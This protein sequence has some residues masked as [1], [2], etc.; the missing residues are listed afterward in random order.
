ME[1]INTSEV[2]SI[3]FKGKTIIEP[4]EIKYINFNGYEGGVQIYIEGSGEVSYRAY[5]TQL[6]KA[7]IDS[8]LEKWI[9]LTPLDEIT[10]QDFSIYP[11]INILKVENKSSS[12]DN[13]LVTWGMKK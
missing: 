1:F 11:G 2:D 4:S 8:G 9:P 5:V 3:V 10:E 7:D 12:T 13:L 6:N